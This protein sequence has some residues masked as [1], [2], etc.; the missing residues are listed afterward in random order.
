MCNIQNKSI[1]VNFVINWIDILKIFLF[2]FQV[3]KFIHLMVYLSREIIWIIRSEWI[4]YLHLFLSMIED[5]STVHLYGFDLSTWWAC[6]AQFRS[7]KGASKKKSQRVSSRTKQMDILPK[8]ALERALRMYLHESM[9][10]DL[11]AF[12][13]IFLLAS[14]HQDM[15]QVGFRPISLN[16][17]ILVILS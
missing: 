8:E 10:I 17:R 3:F 12:R 14:L 9:S 15:L 2:I 6:G 4:V 5:F 1:L 16:P 11:Q 13:I 7:S